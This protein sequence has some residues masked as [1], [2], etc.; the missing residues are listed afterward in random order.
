[1]DSLSS[2]AAETTDKYKYRRNN[3]RK[4]KLKRYYPSAKMKGLYFCGRR[5]EF[6][7]ERADY[8]RERLSN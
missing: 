2:G 7:G 4:M 3:R 1:L 6:C 5:R 8:R